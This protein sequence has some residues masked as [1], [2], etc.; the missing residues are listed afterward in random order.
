[1]NRFIQFCIPLLLLVSCTPATP[2]TDHEKT[3]IIQEVKQTLTNYYRDIK[4][5]GLTA[6][7]NYLDNSADFYWVP[8]NYSTPITYDSVVTVLKQNAPKFKLVD[9]FFETLRIFPLNTT[10]ATYYGRIRSSMTDTSGNTSSFLLL[11]T[12]ILIKRKEGWKLL[13]GQTKVV[14]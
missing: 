1:M 12:G 3:A 13:S 11:E 8:P 4:A 6:E 14:N 10:L 5:N 7:F 2:L 9:N